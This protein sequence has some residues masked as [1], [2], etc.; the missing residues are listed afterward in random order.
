LIKP[1]I[2]L[3]ILAISLVLVAPCLATAELK[4]DPFVG[5]YSRTS[6]GAT[7]GIKETLTLKANMTCTLRAVYSGRKPIVQSGTWSKEGTSAKIIL[8]SDGQIT[9]K[10]T[11]KLQGN[12]LIATE[13]DK[14]VWGDAELKYTKVR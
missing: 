1:R 9:D 13:Y 14:S 8:K 4:K 12:Q 5:T 7:G 6:I 10:I 3:I 11:F 2:T